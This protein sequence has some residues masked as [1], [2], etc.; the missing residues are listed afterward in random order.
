[1]DR[2]KG[3]NEVDFVASGQGVE[4]YSM[5]QLPMA[6]VARWRLPLAGHH[7]AGIHSLRNNI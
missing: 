1:M 6:G 2:V 7:S 5:V 4:I 3:M